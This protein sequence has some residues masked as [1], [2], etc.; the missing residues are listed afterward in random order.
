MV[1]FLKITAKKLKG[2]IHFVDNA[3]MKIYNINVI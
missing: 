2:N 1:I 3:C